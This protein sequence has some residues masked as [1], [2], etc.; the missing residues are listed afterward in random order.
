MVEKIKAIIDKMIENSCEDDDAVLN[1][2][3]RKDLKWDNPELV[4][5]LYCFGNENVLRRAIQ[6]IYPEFETHSLVFL[7]QHYGYLENQIK[8]ILEPLASDGGIADKARWVLKQWFCQ[9]TKQDVDYLAERKWYHPD[10]GNTNF[11]IQF[12][13]IC[14]DIYYHGFTERNLSHMMIVQK[15]AKEALEQKIGV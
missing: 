4:Y 6:M 15:L 5:S 2:L 8:S 9:L 14:M 12:C 13:E 7:F 10:F 11:W 1:L 3:Q